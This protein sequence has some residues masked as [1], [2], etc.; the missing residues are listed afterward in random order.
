MLLILDPVDVT[1]NHIKKVALDP[2]N[3][4]L[5]FYHS[6]PDVRAALTKTA[7]FDGKDDW[8]DMGGFGYAAFN[9]N[10]PDATNIAY[11]GLWFKLEDR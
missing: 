6:D 2:S 7:E 10:E 9:A 5:L 1:L 8:Q 4:H 3:N 11:S